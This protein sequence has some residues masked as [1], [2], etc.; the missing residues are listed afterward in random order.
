MGAME[1]WPSLRGHLDGLR[2][3][4][5]LTLNVLPS[6]AQFEREVTDE[7]IRDE[8]GAS[9]RRGLGVMPLGH[10]SRDKRL[11]IEEEEVERV[12]INFRRYLE[13]CTLSQLLGDLRQ[14]GIV[15]GSRRLSDGR[16]IGGT[17]FTRRPLA[18]LLGNRF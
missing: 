13:L 7:R 1:C 10:V 3:M 8:I 4:G 16:T 2:S 9:K 15:T 18:C 5:R 17:P 11:F 12:R 6:F 14:R